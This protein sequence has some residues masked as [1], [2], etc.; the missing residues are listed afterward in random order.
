M[1]AVTDPS[2][3]ISLSALGVG[4]LEMEAGLQLQRWKLAAGATDRRRL[5]LEMEGRRSTPHSTQLTTARDTRVTKP[6]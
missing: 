6:R 3:A 1:K 2:R 5:L 4:I